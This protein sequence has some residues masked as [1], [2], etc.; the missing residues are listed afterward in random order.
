MA[1]L[2]MVS[3]AKYVGVNEKEFAPLETRK[4]ML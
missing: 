3:F 2:K 1:G 4:R